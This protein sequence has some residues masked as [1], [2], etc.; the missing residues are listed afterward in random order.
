MRAAAIA[1]NMRRVTVGHVSIWWFTK[2][3]VNAEINGM[4]NIHNLSLDLSESKTASS[5][6]ETSILIFSLHMVEPSI[7]SV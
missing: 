1:T 2:G 5:V 7:T 3:I 6:I 4:S